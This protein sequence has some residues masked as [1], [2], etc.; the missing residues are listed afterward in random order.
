MN[1]EEAFEFL[2]RVAQ[3]IAA[4]FG[5]ECETVVHEMNNNQIINAAIFNGHVSGRSVGSTL[6]IYGKDTLTDD[7]FESDLQSDYLNQLVTMPSGKTVKSTTF[8][9][10]G[11]DYHYAL[12]INYDITVM[13]QMYHILEHMTAVEGDLY[14]SLSG[15][16]Q[17]NIEI[18]FQ[19]C[20]EVINK[21]IEQMKKADRFAMVKLLK[22]KGA[23]F[24]QR[25]VPYVAERLGI[26]KYTVYNYLN[27]I[28][29]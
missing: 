9:M 13:N 26:S 16:E 22:E 21:P 29:E 18:L 11:Q 6:S 15:K 19:A 20:L 7:D 23:F 2:C 27:Q 28:G 12:G 10:H 4:T 3:G 5:S 17:T 25:S 8:H 24:M 14:M 1:K